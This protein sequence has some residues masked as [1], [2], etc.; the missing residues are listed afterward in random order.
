MTV[1]RP[2]PLTAV[3]LLGALGNVFGTAVRVFDDQALDSTPVKAL[4][5]TI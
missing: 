5:C 2:T 4:T 3:G 1:A